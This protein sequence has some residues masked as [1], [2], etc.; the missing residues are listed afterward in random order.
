MNGIIGMTQL[1][2]DTSLSADQ[3]DYLTLV[4]SSAQSLLHII[5]DI[6]DFSRIEAGKVELEAEPVPV[7][8][9]IQSLIR[10]HMPGAS[11]KGIELLV[12]IAPDV[13]DV[14]LVDGARL[15]QIL[16]NLL[17]NALKFTHQGKLS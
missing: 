2:L 12:D 15:R 14:L 3:R 1:C 9:F 17:G 11:E 6:L 13:P 10:P 5:N 4:M 7:R 16:T 8:P